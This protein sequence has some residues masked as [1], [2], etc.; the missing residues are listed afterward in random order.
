MLNTL[1][2]L[3]QSPAR[4]AALRSSYGIVAT[5]SQAAHAARLAPGIRSTHAGVYRVGACTVDLWRMACT[6]KAARNHKASGQTFQP[7]VHYLALYLAAE[8]CPADPDPVAYLRT[9]GV[10]QPEIVQFRARVHNRAGI[11][12]LGAP[13]HPWGGGIAWYSLYLA[14]HEIGAA[15]LCE[16]SHVQPVYAEEI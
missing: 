15:P 11:Y 1:S 4:L 2:H 16:I 9:A 8:W 3:T 13:F 12:T 6:C 10:E 5:P 14:G 7:C